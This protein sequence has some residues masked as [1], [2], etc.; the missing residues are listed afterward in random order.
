[1]VI[2]PFDYKPIDQVDLWLQ[3]SD[4]FLLKVCIY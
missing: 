4:E 1:M 2:E 3:Q